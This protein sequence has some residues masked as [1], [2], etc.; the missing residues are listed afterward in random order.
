MQD[1]TLQVSEAITLINQT[2]DSA[3]P[4]ILVEGEVSGFKVN[5]GKFV[6]FDVK[7]ESGSL[8][9]FMMA[10]ALKFPL[11]D[12]M[13]VR[14]LAQPKLTAWGKFSL[15]VREVMPV[16]EG[17]LKK[18]FELLKAKLEKE[19]L[20][21]D[22]RKRVLPPIPK[23]IGVVSSSQA[24]GYA[25]FIKILENRWGGLEIVLVDV[26]VQGIDAPAQVIGAI[27]HLNELAEPVDV[28]AVIRGGGSADDL[29]VFNHEGVVRAIA[30]SRAPVVVGVGHEVDTSLSDLVADRRAATPSNTAE[31]IVPDKVQVLAGVTRVVHTAQ[32]G[33]EAAIKVFEMDRIEV[34][35]SISS[36]LQTFL[37]KQTNTLV[38]LRRTLHQL[39][40]HAVLQRGY[41]LVKKDGKVVTG[42]SDVIIGDDIIIETHGGEIGASVIHVGN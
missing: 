3:F 42:T 25:D 26:P 41:S 30:A 8:G 29:S 15:T 10:F 27:A 7:D 18:S 39:D 22:S 17:S 4:F 23:R 37:E 35:D 5:Q 33:V 6:F 34:Q 16:G 2:L 19:G 36:S 14:V 40:P 20:F 24:A 1:V 21:D 12:G 31:I 38:S 13:K 32:S 9:C 11:E 28:L